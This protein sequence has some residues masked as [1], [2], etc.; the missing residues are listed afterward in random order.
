ME[1][2][3]WMDHLNPK[4]K[5]IWLSGLDEAGKSTIVRLAMQRAEREGHLGASFFFSRDTEDRSTADYLFSTISYQLTQNVPKTAQL[6]DSIMRETPN[7]PS[8][9]LKTQFRELIDR[10][11]R[12]GKMTTI[13]Y[14]LVGIHGLNECD[15]ERVQEKLVAIIGE[16]VKFQ[17]PLR[18]LISSCPDSR[19]QMVL[20]KYS[21]FTRRISLGTSDEPV[22]S[23]FSYMY[24]GFEDMKKRHSQF[25]QAIPPPWPASHEEWDI[26]RRSL[27][28]FSYV[29]TLLKFVGGNE[30]LNP[31]HQLNIVL[32]PSL[33]VTPDPLTSPYPELDRLYLLVLSRH[34]DPPTL[35]RILMF[36]VTPNF[37]PFPDLLDD[38]LNVDY[39]TVSASLGHVHPLVD[40]SASDSVNYPSTLRHVS[41]R[42]FLNDPSRS[43]G[44]HI[45]EQS[46][47]RLVR[48]ACFNLMIQWMG[49]AA[50]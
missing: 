11:A 47:S 42:D 36:F 40:F 25:M 7:L 19:I 50:R 26:K 37:E 32:R 4:Y 1:L 27:G 38:L 2:S 10:P 46:S 41:F 13:P 22:S 45:N 20:K 17:L 15:N 23:L 8:M 5:I 18:F 12:E 33:E 30:Y 31:V 24:E 14:P 39:G 43:Q 16:A 34:P 48:R 28:Q 49:Q 3:T 35:L 6:I 29:D 44:F 21:A 9:S